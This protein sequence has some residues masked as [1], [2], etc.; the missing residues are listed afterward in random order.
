MSA[1]YREGPPFSSTRLT[2]IIVEYRG[3][4]LRR[5]LVGGVAHQHTGLPHRPIPHHH[6]LDEFQVALIRHF[7]SPCRMVSVYNI[8]TQPIRVRLLLI[9]WALIRGITDFLVRLR[10]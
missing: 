2:C 7:W 8:D 10:S 5:E 4:V 3:Y 1:S 6:T 9:D